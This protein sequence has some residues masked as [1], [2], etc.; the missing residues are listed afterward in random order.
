MM[1]IQE[2]R[3]LIK[4]IR[5]VSQSYVIGIGSQSTVGKNFESTNLIAML[6]QS[7]ARQTMKEVF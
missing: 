5:A 4:Y 2:I 6:K 3:T 7:A 1:P